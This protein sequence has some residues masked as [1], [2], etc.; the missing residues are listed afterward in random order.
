MP[1]ISVSKIP[2]PF[3]GAGGISWASYWATL[4][5]A[6]VE[7]AAP[8]HVVLTFP[9]AQTSLGASDFTIAGFTISSASWAD[10]VLTLVLSYGVTY[11]SGNLTITFVKTGETAIVTNNVAIT[12]TVGWYVAGDGSATYVTKDANDLVSVWKDLSGAN[13]HLTQATG[14][15]QPS[16]SEAGI[17]FVND[18]LKSPAFTYNAPQMVYGVFTVK[19]YRQY[20][21]IINGLNDAFRIRTNADDKFTFEN[22]IADFNIGTEYIFRLLT[23]G[24]SSF[25]KINEVSTTGTNT[26]DDIGG[27]TL[28]NTWTDSGVYSNVEFKELIFRTA[29]DSAA[30]E[31]SIYNYLANKYGLTPI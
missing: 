10:A 28:G 1:G 12:D 24:A 14:S 6:T 19:S 16:Y 7:N 18:S 30:I 15:K 23:N 21:T 8:T 11:Y 9:T 20:Q 27:I 5:S 22:I 25:C 17:L 26:N 4:I 31:L 2:I 3:R 13:H 29:T